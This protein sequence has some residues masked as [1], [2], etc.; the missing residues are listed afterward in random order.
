MTKETNTPTKSSSTDSGSNTAEKQVDTIVER[1]PAGLS[2]DQVLKGS[3]DAA[4]EISEKAGEEAAA[5]ERERLSGLAAAFPDNSDFVA[6]CVED[7]STVEQAKAKRYDTVAEELK[8]ANAEIDKLK[9][10]VSNGGKPSFVASDEDEDDSDD[11]D[12]SVEALEAAGTKLWNADAELREEFNGKK[13]TFLAD[14]RRNP[15]D[16]K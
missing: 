11:E 5:A 7:G 16:Y 14:Y 3:P 9:K 12:D 13:S 10:A 8:T 2:A 15:D 1:T 6:E 4:K